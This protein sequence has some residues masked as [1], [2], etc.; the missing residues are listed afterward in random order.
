[1]PLQDGDEVFV[2]IPL[3]LALR[4]R[5]DGVLS[6]L[7]LA[8]LIYEGL[9]GI[10][11]GPHQT[12]NTHAE[13]RSAVRGCKAAFVVLEGSR[14]ETGWLLSKI[15]ETGFQQTDVF[16]YV[17]GGSEPPVELP[18]IDTIRLR[19]VA[20]ARDFETRLQA[21]ALSLLEVAPRTN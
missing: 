16:V 6:D 18:K 14:P 21:D 12:S 2:S 10:Q 4:R 9:E 5:T 8:P 15:T 3:S 19:H 20:D 17:F 1:M 11:L 7:R 13:A